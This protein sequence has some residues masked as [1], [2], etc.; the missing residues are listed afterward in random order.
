MPSAA[1]PINFMKLNP[2]AYLLTRRCSE[3]AGYDLRSMHDVLIH[4]NDKD[5]VQT[6]LWLQLP[7]R[8]VGLIAPCADW[9]LWER[10]G[11][12]HDIIDKTRCE[13]LS[14]VI[15]NHTSNQLQIP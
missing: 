12:V 6:D 11:V 2:M 8:C 15:W 10:L 4:P 9:G 13:N 5:E 3:A 7:E 14:M 1:A